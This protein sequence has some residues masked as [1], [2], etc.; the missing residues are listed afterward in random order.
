MTNDEKHDSSTKDNILLRMDSIPEAAYTISAP[1][2]TDIGV[3]TQ[4]ADKLAEMIIELYD[5]RALE[6]AYIYESD[7]GNDFAKL[8]TK[9]VVAKLGT[10]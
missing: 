9:S 2:T 8:V 7:L 10:Q 3:L 1:D 5:K 6:M 4:Q